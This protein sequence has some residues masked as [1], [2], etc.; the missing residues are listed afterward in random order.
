MP[1]FERAIKMEEENE[2]K[3][4]KSRKK[5]DEVAEKQNENETKEKPTHIFQNESLQ[6]VFISQ[7]SRTISIA[8]SNLPNGWNF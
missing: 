1:R 6:M 3:N 8:I 7:L 5:M 2:A 4:W